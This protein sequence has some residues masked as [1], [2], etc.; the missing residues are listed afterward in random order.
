MGRKYVRISLGGARDE[1][2]IRGHRRTYIGAMPGRILQGMKQAGAQAIPSSCSTRWTSSAC[3]SRATPR[4]PCSRCSTRRRTTASRTT[5][6]AFPSTSRRSS[7]SRRPTS[8]RTFRRPLLDRM[9]VVNFA[10]YTE[11]EKLE[12]AKTY[13][14]P[15]Q[16]EENGLVAGAAH[17]ARRRDPG[18]D[19]ELHAGVRRAPARARARPSRPQ[20]RP[21]HRGARDRI[22]RRSRR[23]DPGAARPAQGPPGEE[24]ARR[25]DR[26][27]HRHV[28]HAGGR[29]HHVRRSLARCGARASSS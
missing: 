14:V 21:A 20:G 11:Q 6:S 1:A 19:C 8:S 12:I 15:R 4:R 26:H 13:L 29:R 25:S 3:P 18:S 22:A 24:G 16:L 17:A 2:D 9:E 27:R 10:G 23:R 28:L 7:S 5:I